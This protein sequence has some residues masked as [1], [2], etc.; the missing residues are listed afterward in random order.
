M[1]YLFVIFTIFNLNAK[2]VNKQ[3]I[4]KGSNWT[5]NWTFFD[6]NT[7]IHTQIVHKGFAIRPYG[8]ISHFKPWKSKKC[9]SNINEMKLKNS[10]MKC[11]DFVN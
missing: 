7:C 3:S 11:H 5:Y 2:N 9:E 1:P 10:S 6:D 8:Y 4:C